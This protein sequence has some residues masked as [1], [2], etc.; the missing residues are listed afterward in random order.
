[1]QKLL[2][3][4]KNQNGPL[5]PSGKWKLEIQDQGVGRFGV[6]GGPSHWLPTAAFLLCSYTAL[7]LTIGVSLCVLISSCK[8]TSQTELGPS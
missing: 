4:S 2:G 6:F 5:W 8:D 3:A 1:M 7:P